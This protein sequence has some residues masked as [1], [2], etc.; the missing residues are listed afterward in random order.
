MYFREDVGR[1]LVS[2]GKYSSVGFLSSLAH[3]AIL[4]AFFERVDF[5]GMDLLDA[6]RDVY[7]GNLGMS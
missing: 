2:T 5:H 4:N 6:I 3:I 1:F 7:K